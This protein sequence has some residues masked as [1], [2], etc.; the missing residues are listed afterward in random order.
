MT[1]SKIATSELER[2]TSKQAQVALSTMVQ[3]KFG[4]STNLEYDFNV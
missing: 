2:S 3:I 4:R 1:S